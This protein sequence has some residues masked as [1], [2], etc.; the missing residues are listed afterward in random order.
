MA[1]ALVA[2][3]GAEAGAVGIDTGS[4]GGG[5]AE[6]LLSAASQRCASAAPS[7]YKHWIT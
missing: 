6:C 2:V 5:S 7:A 1:G 4:D 3:A